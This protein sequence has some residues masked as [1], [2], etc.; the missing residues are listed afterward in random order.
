MQFARLLCVLASCWSVCLVK[1]RTCNALFYCPINI[2]VMHFLAAD[3]AASEMAPKFQALL[4]T[5]C[6]LEACVFSGV[7]CCYCIL[8]AC[9]FMIW[10]AACLLSGTSDSCML[11]ACT[12][13][14][15]CTICL[16]SGPLNPLLDSLGIW[17]GHI[18]L[19][20][21]ISLTAARCVAAPYAL[22]P[23]AGFFC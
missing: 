15:C 20:T 13:S 1:E 3:A 4:C 14:L 7:V 16:P 21:P 22:M 23:S 5:C 8:M 19:C 12:C 18:E 10:F 9:Y 17:R 6:P 11:H 2:P